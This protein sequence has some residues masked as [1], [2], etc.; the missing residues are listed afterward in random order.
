MKNKIAGFLSF[1]A[2]RRRIKGCFLF[3]V[4]LSISISAQA[5][6]DP[7]IGGTSLPDYIQK[8]IDEL[9]A[10]LGN[11]NWELREKATD[12]LIQIGAWAQPSVAKAL[13]H[14][15]AEIKERARQLMTILKWQEIFQIR[16]N[17]FITDLRKGA[18]PDDQLLYQS[19]EFIKSTET[20]PVLVDFLKEPSF[21]ALRQKLIY[22]LANTY[23]IS[24]KPFL[25]DLLKLYENEPDPNFQ[26]VLLMALGRVGPEDSVTA[27]LKTA[28]FSKNYNLTVNAIQTIFQ[29]KNEALLPDLLKLLR[30]GDDNTKRTILYGIYS[31]GPVKVSD[32][33][34]KLLNETPATW[35]KLEIMKILS[36]Y[37]QEKRLLP[38][39]LTMLDSEKDTQIR[40][41]IFAALPR[42]KGDPSITPTL[43]NLL[44]TA[45]PET[46]P[47]MLEFLKQMQDR[48]VIPELLKLLETEKDFIAFNSILDSVQTLA[49]G[50]KFTPDEVPKEL[51]DSIMKQCYDWWEKNKPK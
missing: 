1:V 32:E 21:P 46:R 20:M 3:I 45:T 24:L 44:K 17:K 7:A 16:I 12:E 25:P 29:Q 51:K 19:I 47:R 49:G 43:L 48:V 5:E 10:Q 35:M 50:Q 15:D 36:D 2:P 33:L 11:D 42:Y 9:I 34:L 41:R 39:M 37:F 27:A 31:F 13:N 23:H 28:L 40:D 4:F 18:F 30:E 26:P 14:P 8:R 22:A 6:T 38:I